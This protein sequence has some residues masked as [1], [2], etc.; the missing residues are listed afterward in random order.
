MQCA[1][2]EE[3]IQSYGLRNILL[4]EYPSRWGQESKA[5]MKHKEL[6]DL[7]EALR[8]ILIEHRDHIMQ[9]FVEIP[10]GS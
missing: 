9:I 4:L 10:R 1:A 6:N 8:P 7:K 5:M 2:S 3:I